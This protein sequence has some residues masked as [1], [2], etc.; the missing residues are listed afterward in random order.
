MPEGKVRCRGAGGGRL[1][2]N[3]R[4]PARVPDYFA[5]TSFF[6]WS[7]WRGAGRYL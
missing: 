6:T 7:G 3:R 4:A 5:T 2:S 1:N